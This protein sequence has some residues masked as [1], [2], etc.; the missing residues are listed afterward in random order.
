M[1]LTLPIHVSSAA[2]QIISLV[3]LSTSLIL[4]LAVFNLLVLFQ[5]SIVILQ[6]LLFSA[7]IYEL[8]SL[9]KATLTLIIS[10]LAFLW[11]CSC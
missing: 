2:Y 10:I 7:H 8:I 4:S 5:I 11:G 3:P 9:K 1:W 6:G